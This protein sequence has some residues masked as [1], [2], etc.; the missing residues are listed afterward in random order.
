MLLNF[1]EPPVDVEEALL[2]GQIEHSH[3]TISAL[4]VSFCNCAVSLLAGGIP[5]LK[6][7]RALIY[8]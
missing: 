5:D 8:L 3:Y 6:P 1:R 4:V 2:V 7:D